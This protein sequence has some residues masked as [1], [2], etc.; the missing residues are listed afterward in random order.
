[1]T[2]TIQGEYTPKKENK[3]RVAES[4]DTPT[5][6]TCKRKHVEGGSSA[7]SEEDQEKT[8]NSNEVLREKSSRRRV[9]NKMYTDPEWTNLVNLSIEDILTEK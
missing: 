4:E 8:E 5:K 2:L 7:E 3:E 1:M 6:R 9:P